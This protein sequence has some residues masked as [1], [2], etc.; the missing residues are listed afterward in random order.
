MKKIIFWLLL[1]VG[2]AALC[3]EGMFLFDDALSRTSPDSLDNEVVSLSAA[4]EADAEEDAAKEET[5]PQ[6]TAEEISTDV[7]DIVKASMREHGIDPD[8]VGIVVHDFESDAVYAHNE[9]KYFTAGSTYKV[10]LAV[11]FYEKIADGELS[12]DDTLY[13]D[14]SYYEE[15]GPVGENYQAGDSIP[16]ADLL[17]YVIVDSDNTAAHILIGSLGDWLSFK[18]E[19]AKYSATTI[20]ESDTDYFGWYNVFTAGYMNDVLDHL[21]THR[22]I[23]GTLINDLTHAKPDDYLNGVLGGTKMAQKYG[24]YEEAENAIGFSTSGH[25]YSIA[26]YTSLGYTGREWMGEVNADIWHYFQDLDETRQ[27]AEEENENDR[28]E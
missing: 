3:L 7:A 16:V 22:D 28:A 12:L 20:P 27:A 14:A 11:L 25:P 5:V 9:T 6:K 24:Q 2:L 15:G 23:F 4:V 21:Y 26:V 19:T 18:K 8:Q 17:Q 1:V 10:P 13:Y